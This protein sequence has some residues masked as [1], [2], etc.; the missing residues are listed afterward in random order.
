MFCHADVQLANEIRQINPPKEIENKL[1]LCYLR[2][3]ADILS[4]LSTSH[5]I[6]FRSLIH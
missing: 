6:I 3:C 4:L 2:R 1:M 5:E